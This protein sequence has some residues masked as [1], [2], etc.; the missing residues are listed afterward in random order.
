MNQER[1]NAILQ[2]LKDGKPLTDIKVYG[3][4]GCVWTNT[5]CIV[6]LDS[7]KGE[8]NPRMAFNY[9]TSSNIGCPKC[10]KILEQ[11][12]NGTITE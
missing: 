8:C 7:I 9:C 12:A 2:S 5:A 6:E 10:I 4:R 11:V 3:N 1:A